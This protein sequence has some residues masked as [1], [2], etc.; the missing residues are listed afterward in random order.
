MFDHFVYIEPCARR[1][2]DRAEVVEHRDGLIVI[3]ADGAGGTSGGAEAADTVMLW[4]RAFADRT[5][6]IRSA[7][8]WAEL[9]AKVD[10]Q[11]QL[12]NGQT[13]AVIVALFDDGIVGA[14]VGDSA[15]WII[16]PG[17]GYIDLTSAQVHKPLIGAGGAQAV[18]FEHAQIEGALLV[19]SDGLVK[20]APPA[21]ICSA[22][23]DPE[24]SSAAKRM[25][26]LTRLKSGALWDDVAV[27]LCR[28]RR[29]ANVSSHARRKRYSLGED[30]ELVEDSDKQPDSS[31]VSG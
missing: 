7:S 23:S 28:R 14:S 22:A 8:K 19:A 15:A 9:L 18:P 31:D 2:Q 13:T 17:G 30:G 26:D 29:A 20:Y 16:K 4:A 6:D 5:G 3:L 11:L 10:Q 27:V 25:V 12:N 24:I 1:G 21:Q